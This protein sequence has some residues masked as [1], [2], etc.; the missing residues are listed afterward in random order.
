MVELPIDAEDQENLTG[1]REDIAMHR[2]ME[3]MPDKIKNLFCYKVKLPH[4]G[5]RSPL[6][7]FN[8]LDFDQAQN[9]LKRGSSVVV[10]VL[11]TQ[12]KS[13]KKSYVK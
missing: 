8:K 6:Q 13:V 9:P 5:S 10:Q 4:I 7:I 11:K 3:I 1:M 2:V 12:S